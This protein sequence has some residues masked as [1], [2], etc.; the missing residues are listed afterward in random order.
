[1]IVH[2][3]S[4][5]VMS[6]EVSTREIPDV[7]SKLAELL[8]SDAVWCSSDCCPECGVADIDRDEAEVAAE[9][10]AVLAVTYSEFMGARRVRM[11]QWAAYDLEQAGDAMRYAL[12]PD[13]VARQGWTREAATAILRR[14]LYWRDRAVLGR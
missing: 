7:V 6:R 3:G 5:S 12:E 4:A 14:A 2:V 11:R 1:M 8:G 10:G 13:V 9:R